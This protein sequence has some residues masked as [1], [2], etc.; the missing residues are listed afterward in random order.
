MPVINARFTMATVPHR[1]PRTFP[2]VPTAA[3]V[4][5]RLGGGDGVSVEAAKWSW[6]LGELG[7]LVRSVAGVGAVD[8]LVPGLAIDAQDPPRPGEVEDAL[9]GAD[10]VVVENLCSLPLNPAAGAAVAGACRGR[11]AL[12]HHHDLPWQ[13]PHLRHHPAPPDDPGWRHVVINELSRLQLAERGIPAVTIRNAFDTEAAP[14]DREAT[15]HRLGQDAGTRLFLQP[16]RALYRK[17]V[18][19][20]LALAE[21]LGG[22][23]WLLGPAEDGFGPQLGRI[24]SGA[25]CPVLRGA[26]PEDPG[27]PTSVPDLYAASDVVVLPSTWEGFGNP[28]VESAVLRRP[29]AVGPYP[30]ARELVEFGF[31]WFTL[32]RPG[33][34]ARW[35]DDPDESLLDHN[36]A[37]ARR[38]FSLRDLPGRLAPVLDDL[39]G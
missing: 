13:R 37:V 17:N 10:L 3:I 22:T 23:F 5:Y 28:T 9:A 8:R 39:L 35:L 27:R 36:L 15:R 34:L 11:P 7:W 29:L 14:G 32:G 25:R 4:S 30:V 2:W 19:G 12:L 6:A 26:G 33:R 38:H 18:P 21:R 31:R 1:W 16:T 24:L 20:G